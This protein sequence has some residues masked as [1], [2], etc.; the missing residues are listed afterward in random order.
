MEFVKA[1]SHTLVFTITHLIAAFIVIKYY[2]LGTPIPVKRLT[3][4]FFVYYMV[5]MLLAGWFMFMTFFIVPTQQRQNMLL[6]FLLLHGLAFLLIYYVYIR[7]MVWSMDLLATS[8]DPSI[9]DGF[10]DEEEY[11]EIVN[12]TLGEKIRLIAKNQKKGGEP[13]PDDTMSHIVYH[14]LTIQIMM[15]VVIGIYIGMTSTNLTSVF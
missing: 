10:L 6:K 4:S 13:L 1:Y 9:F 3:S 12:M 15:S 2:L 8:M 14:S 7:N 5:F 11:P